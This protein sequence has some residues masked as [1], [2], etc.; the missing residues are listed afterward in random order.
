MVSSAGRAELRLRDGCVTPRGRV[1]RHVP[2]LSCGGDSHGTLGPGPG[3]R[4]TGLSA[5]PPLPSRPSLGDGMERAHAGTAAHGA[6]APGR[7]TQEDEPVAFRQL[8]QPVQ[9]LIRE[10]DPPT[11]VNRSGL[12]CLC[13]LPRLRE[14]WCSQA[15]LPWREVST[16]RVPYPEEGAAGRLRVLV[17]ALCFVARWVPCDLCTEA[18]AGLVLACVGG[19]GGGCPSER[20]A[21]ARRMSLEKARAGLATPISVCWVLFMLTTH[22]HTSLTHT[23]TCTRVRGQGLASLQTKT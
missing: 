17:T 22:P 15:G 8:C 16:L 11:W 23:Y 2:R 7:V 20:P 6:A 4:S 10:A 3:R 12:S 18:G 13:S 21:G 5:Q 19:A 9:R 14:G 1:S